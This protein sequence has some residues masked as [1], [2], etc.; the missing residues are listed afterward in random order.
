MREV[1]LRASKCSRFTCA[2][3][4]IIGTTR[5]D[6][7]VLIPITAMDTVTHHLYS[8]RLALVITADTTSGVTI[9]VAII[10][11]AIISVAIISVAM[12]DTTAITEFAERA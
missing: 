3:I 8:Y 7:I 10:S 12:A 5:I 1:L 11:V 6:V 9:S 4:V 2:G